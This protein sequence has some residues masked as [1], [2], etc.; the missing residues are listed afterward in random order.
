M[1]GRFD[2][3]VSLFFKGVLLS[4]GPQVDP[5]YHGA[6]FCMLFNGRDAPAELKMGEHFATLEFCAL[7]SRIDGYVGRHQDKA[8]LNQF[9]AAE[10]GAGPG[11]ILLDALKPRKSR[12]DAM[13]CG[14]GLACH[15]SCSTCRFSTLGYE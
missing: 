6:L 8:L 3:T 10:T 1:A 7:G 12:L 14:R 9:L 5:G 11:A 13:G 2:L 15:Y 4:N